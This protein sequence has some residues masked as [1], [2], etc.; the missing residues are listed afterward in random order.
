VSPFE[1]GVV[2]VLGCMLGVVFVWGYLLHE[3]ELEIR[4]ELR[5]LNAYLR[6]TP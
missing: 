4:T 6:E 1:W 3:R 5:R 2:I